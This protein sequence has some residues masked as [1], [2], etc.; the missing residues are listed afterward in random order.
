MKSLTVFK[1]NEIMVSMP[2]KDITLEG[3][4]SCHPTFF[5]CPKETIPDFTK[6][7]SKVIDYLYGITTTIEL[8]IE[9][10]RNQEKVTLFPNLDEM[11][12]FYNEL[13]QAQYKLCD[14]HQEIGKIDTIMNFAFTQKEESEKAPEWSIDWE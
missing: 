4:S 14:L 9:K 13:S 8:K 7:L 6:Y 12:E 1:D 5:L 10:L 3:L 11:A 2:I